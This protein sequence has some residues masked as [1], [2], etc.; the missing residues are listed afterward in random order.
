MNKFILILIFCIV[1]VVGSFF[2]KNALFSSK[3]ETDKLISQNNRTNVVK[4]NNENETK[5]NES[6]KEKKYI[7]NELAGI[8]LGDS[9]EIVQAKLG[10]PLRN[11]EKEAE[12]ALFYDG[13][14]IYLKQNIVSKIYVEQEGFKT[15][16]GLQ[17]RIYDGLQI[18]QLT[19]LYGEPDSWEESDNAES[20]R[21]KAL[22]FREGFKFVAEVTEEGHIVAVWIQ[23]I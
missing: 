10:Q 8:K 1:F 15:P 11:E 9:L 7:E 2:L 17:I 14:V 23:V 21:S 18:E 6:K 3:V 22:Y 5:I 20:G 19:K 4:K 16:K 12:N 13:I